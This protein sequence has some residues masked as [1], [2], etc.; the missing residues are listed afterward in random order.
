MMKPQGLFSE[1][2]VPLLE[3]MGWPVGLPTLWGRCSHPS[4]GCW[5]HGSGGMFSACLDAQVLSIC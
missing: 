1:W 3:G 4:A 5:R 2:Q